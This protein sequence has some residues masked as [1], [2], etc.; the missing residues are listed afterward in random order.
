[1]QA[2]SPPGARLDEAALARRRAAKARARRQFRSNG[3]VGSSPAAQKGGRGASGRSRA[4]A[5]MLATRSREPADREGAPPSRAEPREAARA[6]SFAEL[7]RRLSDYGSRDRRGIVASTLL[8]LG[9]LSSYG[10]IIMLSS[11][12][13]I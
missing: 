2:I 11:H 13:L 5:W 10:L 12:G 4:A 1:M 9:A 6:S 8:Q 3:R 7:K